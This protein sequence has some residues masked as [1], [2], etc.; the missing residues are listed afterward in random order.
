MSKEE[1]DQLGNL[2]FTTKE[3]GTGL[4]ISVAQNIIKKMNGRM[5]YTSKLG[6]GATVHITIPIKS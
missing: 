2:F 5:I 6:E 1:L 4:G 3:F